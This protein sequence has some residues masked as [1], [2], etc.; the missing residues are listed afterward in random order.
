MI[1]NQKDY[2]KLSKLARLVIKTNGVRATDSKF[3]SLK[4]KGIAAMHKPIYAILA[5]LNHLDKIQSI[6]VV[7][8]DG[9]LVI[10]EKANYLL[11]CEH[12]RFKTHVK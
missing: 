11:D 9:I 1:F 3:E 2:T 7:T 12:F 8:S 4:E 5:T 6:Q 10:G